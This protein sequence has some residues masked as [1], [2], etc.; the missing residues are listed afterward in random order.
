MLN[1][2]ALPFKNELLMTLFSQILLFNL[3]FTPQF[4]VM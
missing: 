4:K 1:L 2:V 3:Y